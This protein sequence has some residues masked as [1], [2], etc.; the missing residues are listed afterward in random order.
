MLQSLQHRG[1]DN[2]IFIDEK[3]GLAIGHRR[4]SILDLSSRGSQ[5]MII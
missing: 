5:P 3:H 2:E 1:P 4:L